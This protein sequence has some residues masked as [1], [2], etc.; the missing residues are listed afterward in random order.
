[1]ESTLLRKP[2]NKYGLYEAISKQ[3]SRDK[4]V[5]QTNEG[6]LFFEVGDYVYVKVSPIRGVKRLGVIRKLAPRYVE[7][8]EI[9]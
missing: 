3:L 6:D 4:R 1:M 7:P 8:Y 2:R 5:M 9:N